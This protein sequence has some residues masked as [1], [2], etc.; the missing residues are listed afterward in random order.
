MKYALLAILALSLG[1][2]VTSTGCTSSS[3]PGVKNNV[4]SQWS[5]VEGD[6]TTATNAAKDVLTDM[7]FKD[8]TATSTA[9]DGR[10]IGKKADGTKIT[11]DVTKITDKTST[12]KVSVGTVGE[13]E[14]G[15]D[16]VNKIKTKLGM[17]P[18]T[19]KSM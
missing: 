8:I 14:L 6:T 16:I 15:T 10:A 2:V 5:N 11:V 19:M 4:L 12:V 1:L 7:G 18:T 17:P 13:P 9:V 3:N